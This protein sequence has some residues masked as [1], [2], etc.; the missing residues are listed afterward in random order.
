MICTL[1]ILF[2]LITSHHESPH[3]TLHNI[4]SSPLRNI[5]DRLD[6]ESEWVNGVSFAMPYWHSYDSW[7]LDCGSSGKDLSCR[8]ALVPH[9]YVTGR[10]GGSEVDLLNEGQFCETDWL[11]AKVIITNRDI[12]LICPASNH[13]KTHPD[14]SPCFNH[15][16]I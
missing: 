10:F 16:F 14:P 1:I 9:R 15:V 2:D 4:L 13:P 12:V 8:P 7:H 6:E 3:S 11:N 5:K